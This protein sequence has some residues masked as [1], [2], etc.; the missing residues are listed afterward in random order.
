VNGYASVAT[1]TTVKGIRQE[2]LRNLPLASPPLYE[3][4]AIAEI[5]S[6]VDETIQATQ[7]IIKQTSKIKQ[8]VIKR[9]LSR[10][11]GH[12]CFKQTKIG[13]L[14]EEWQ[15]RRIDEIGE[16]RSGRQ[17]SPHFT[18]GNLRSY[19]RVAN[20]FDGHIDTNDVFQMHFTESEYQR[21]CLVDGDILLN[22]GQSLE[23]VGRNAMY[24]GQPPDCCFQNTLVL[25]RSG[26]EVLNDFA[27]A[28]MQNLFAQGRF[29]EIA[30]RTTSVAHLG[31]RRFGNLLVGVPPLAEQD[32]IAEIHT[33]FVDT[34]ETAQSE[35]SSLISMKSALMSDLLTGRKRV[36]LNDLAAAE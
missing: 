28:L 9:L 36:P 19:L 16:V 34:L 25:F 13:E 30:A 31:T 22:E 5:L 33:Q 21:F 29:M 17:R 2:V 14:P 6:S 15:V 12:T 3:Q 26:N 27:Y 8:E 18:E 7:E 23:L 20:V 35:L 11:I 1:G 10:G 24:K 32:K 4:H